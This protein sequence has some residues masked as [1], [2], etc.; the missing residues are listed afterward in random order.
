M[1]VISRTT[2]L[3]YKG[4]RM[5]TTQIGHDLNIDA[6]VEGTVFHSGNKVRIT[7]Q[8]IQVSTDNHLWAGS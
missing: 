8:L 7:A 6:L 4:T 3:R 2:V 1:R 5:T